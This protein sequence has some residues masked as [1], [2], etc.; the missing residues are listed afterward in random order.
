M[1]AA[2]HPDA[3]PGVPQHPQDHAR[4]PGGR[5][6]PRGRRSSPSATST[7]RS[8]PLAAERAALYERIEEYIRRHYNAYK[9][10]QAS[11]ALGFIMTVYRRRLTSSFEA[12]KKSLQRRLDVLEQGKSLGELLSD[13][14]DIDVEDSLF[15]PEAFDVSARPAPGRNR[16]NCG[17]SSM[18]SNKITGEDT[19]ATRLVAG[20]QPGSR[21][22]YSSVVVFT[23]YTDTMDYVRERLIA[24]GIPDIGC[25]SGRGGEVYDTSTKTGPRSPRPRSRPGSAAVNSTSSSAPTR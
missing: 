19:K 13:D 18:N 25:Y 3:G 5:N 8:S 21:I 9:S 12:I 14:D 15:D 7:T 22:T 1:A 4:V 23:Q 2:P 24:A 10:D 6:H 11:Q 17:P 16:T 20:R